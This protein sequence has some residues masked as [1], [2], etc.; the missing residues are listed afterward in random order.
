LLNH[1][2]TFASPR[3]GIFQEEIRRKTSE[4]NPSAW[5]FPTF[6]AS[7]F[8]WEVE[9]AGFSTFLARNLA[10]VHLVLTIDI[11]VFASGAYL[12]A[13]VPRIPIGVYFPML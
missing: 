4:N 3:V 7:A 10:A 11:T 5:N 6:V 2:P 1:L 9:I 12:C 13:T 8:D